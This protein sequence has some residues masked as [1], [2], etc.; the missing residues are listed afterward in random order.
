MALLD[1]LDKY[2]KNHIIFDFDNTIVSLQIDWSRWFE[3]IEPELINLDEE[4]LKAKREGKISL[5]QLQNLY[6]EKFGDNIR[7]KIIAHNQEFEKA[8]NGYKVNQK[9]VDDIHALKGCK[10]LWTS[11]TRL[12]V[13]P[14]LNEIGLFEEF[15]KMITR[16]DVS[17]VKPEIE[18]FEF[19]Y[20]PEIAKDEY[21]LVGDSGSDEKAAKRAGID[22]YKV[23]HFG[24]FA[25]L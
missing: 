23:T 22:F 10:Y 24:D 8:A 5:S 9:L 18:G 20:N 19:I 2:P 13:V 7:D 12:T 16:S 15:E 14:I 17:F 1:Y 3:G 6:V 25:S 21:L 11:N 4:I